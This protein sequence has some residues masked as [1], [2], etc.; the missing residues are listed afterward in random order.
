[1]AA[2]ETWAAG[3]WVVRAGSEDEFV[4]RW[5]AWLSWTSEN[6]SGFRSATLIRSENDG[7]RFESFSDWDD[8]GARAQWEASDGF[9]EGI[10]PV[11]EL[12][13]DVQT[14]NFQRAASFPS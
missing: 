14:G 7:R 4:N 8:A 6:A 5:K 9:K 2:S 13:E 12:C 3:V 1:M 10:A 11:R